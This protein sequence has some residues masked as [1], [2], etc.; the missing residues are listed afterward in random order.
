MTK[1][2]IIHKCDI[3]KEAV[4]DKDVLVKVEAPVEAYDCEGRST[5]STTKVI[6]M[7]PNCRVEYLDTVRKHFAEVYVM[8]DG[9]IETKRKI[10]RVVD[11]ND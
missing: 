11:C 5:Y 8:P 1:T 4:L 7:C 10:E 3:C 9:L 6:D 2:T